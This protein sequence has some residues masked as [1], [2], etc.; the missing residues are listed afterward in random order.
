LF[1]HD[2]SRDLW[3]TV[4]RTKLIILLALI[5]QAGCQTLPD[6]RHDRLYT[7]PVGMRGSNR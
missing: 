3:E 6:N 4:M 5:V 2:F 7:P 1:N